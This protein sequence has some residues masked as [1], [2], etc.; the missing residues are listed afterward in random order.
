M[1]K[2]WRVSDWL[3]CWNGVNLVRRILTFHGVFGRSENGWE[4][5]TS[6]L[7]KSFK[8]EC[9]VLGHRAPCKCLPNNTYDECLKL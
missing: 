5:F 6:L 7:M 9:L 8:F 3:N 2:I 4:V 1:E